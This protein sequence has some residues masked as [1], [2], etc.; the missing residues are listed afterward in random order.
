MNDILLKP[1]VI[2]KHKTKTTILVDHRLVYILA[3]LNHY[4][5]LTCYSKITSDTTTTITKNQIVEIRFKE[6]ASFINFLNKVQRKDQKLAA[7]LKEKC[8][9]SLMMLFPKFSKTIIKVVF[10]FDN[11]AI[12]CRLFRNYV[13]P[14]QK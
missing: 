7:F 2:R 6:Y 13:K 5:L 10:D 12:F 9:I 8:T 11:L 4:G 1:L 14:P 3:N